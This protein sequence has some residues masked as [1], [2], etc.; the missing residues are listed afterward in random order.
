MQGI[1]TMTQSYKH[2]RAISCVSSPI[3]NLSM[4]EVKEF[5]YYHLRNAECQ[6]RQ[7]QANY[8]VW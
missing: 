6:N 3:L 8:G 7:I 1:L 2:S 4:T 5:G